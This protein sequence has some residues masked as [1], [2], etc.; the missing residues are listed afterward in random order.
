[1][2]NTESL[3]NLS[4]LKIKKKTKNV[5][6]EFEESVEEKVIWYFSK[7][8]TSLIYLSTPILKCRFLPV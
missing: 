7:K 6:I 5:N 3:N 8:I 1:M 2:E 4:H